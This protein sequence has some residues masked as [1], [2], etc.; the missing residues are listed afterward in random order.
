MEPGP[1]VEKGRE[2][3]NIV[4]FCFPKILICHFKYVYYLLTLLPYMKP[5]TQTMFSI[6]SASLLNISKNIEF[7][8][9]KQNTAFQSSSKK[10]KHFFISGISIADYYF[11]VWMSDF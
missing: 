11:Q 3:G 5:Y 8:L 9:S 10:A 7:K 6:L 1:N 2:G 4:P